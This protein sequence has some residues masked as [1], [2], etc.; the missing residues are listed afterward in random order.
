L[1]IAL[2]V[3]AQSVRADDK[4]A[5]ARDAIAAVHYDDAQGLLVQ[6]LHA[7]NNGLVELVE[8]YRL[9]ASTA[10]V[11]GQEDVAE[12]YYKR[13]LEL[14]P[15]ATL[16]ESV[17]PKLRQPFVTAQAYMA[18]HGRLTVTARRRKDTI[19]VVVESDPL[20]MVASIAFGDDN[21]PL[22]ADH[23]AHSSIADGDATPAVA[24]LDEFG[25]RLDELRGDEIP[26]DPI[27]VRI[28]SAQ[29][30]PAPGTPLYARPLAWVALGAIVGGTG[31]GFALA[32]RSAQHDVND[33]AANPS[34]H[35]A[36][37]LADARDRRDRDAVIA[38]IGF[39]IGG[40]CILTGAVIWLLSKNDTAS[41]IAFA[42][43]PGGGTAT[44]SLSF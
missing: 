33:I 41:T 1:V 44:M 25:N 39:G 15:N 7:G 34:Q 37:D 5:K 20:G 43:A 17:A 28:G 12:Q 19:D 31:V 29:Q 8:I 23:A 32:A 11:L 36:S 4:L 30:G 38:N 42:P 6:A 2:V 10:I 26:R 3:G 14:V 40:A 21:Q 16:P 24:V 22:G 18:A 27:A 9:S 35:F 13:W